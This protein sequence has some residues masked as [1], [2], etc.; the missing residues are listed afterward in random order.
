M[1]NKKKILFCDN[2]LRELIN[3]RKEVINNYAADGFEVVLVAPKNFD[4]VPAYKNIR[5]IPICMSRSGMNLFDELKY[6]NE[7]RRIYRRECPNY[8]FHYTIKPNIYGSIAA[9][10]CHIP[11]TAMVAGLGYVFNKDGVGNSI[12][13]A[14]Y[15]FAL[16][17]SEYVFVLNDYNRQ[18][19]LE[20]KM[21]M[22]NQI[23]LLRGGEGVDLEIFNV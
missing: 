7:L 6:F 15:R 9:R 1:L 13:R 18:V 17:R 21:V 2:S 20:R 12:A 22:E 16:R 3:F 23:V 4:Y 10:W 5:Y 8:I 19:L 14:L 11:S